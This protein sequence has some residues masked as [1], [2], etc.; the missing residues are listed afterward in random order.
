MY[1]LR[2][3]EAQSSVVYLQIASS[4]RKTQVRNCRASHVLPIHLMVGDNLLDV[5][6]WREFVLNKMM[7][8]DDL[9]PLSRHEP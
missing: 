6:R 9:N 3:D 8:I 4:R 1:L 2:R 5:H 7:G